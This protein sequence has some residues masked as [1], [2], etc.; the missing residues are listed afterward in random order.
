M[1]KEKQT[2][3]QDGTGDKP[4]IITPTK[5]INNDTIIKI[6]VICIIIGVVVAI[7][8]SL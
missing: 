2:L 8:C 3:G 5:K 7:I 1:S 4:G 6:I